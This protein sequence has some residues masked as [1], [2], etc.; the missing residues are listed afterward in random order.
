MAAAQRLASP[1]ATGP[2][3]SSKRSLSGGRVILTSKWQCQP[4]GTRPAWRVGKE[5]ASHS[6]ES[7]PRAL[8]GGL[9]NHPGT[10]T[11]AGLGRS[12]MGVT[13]LGGMGRAPPGGPPP[14]L[15]LHQPWAS[16]EQREPPDSPPPSPTLPR[17]FPQMPGF[18]FHPNEDPLT[19]AQLPALCAVSEAHPQGWPVTEGGPDPL[20]AG[21]EEECLSPRHGAAETTRPLGCCPLYPGGCTQLAQPPAP[22]PSWEGPVVSGGA[23]RRG[24]AG[25]ASEGAG[26]GGA[27]ASA[28]DSCASPGAAR[29][30]INTCRL[31]VQIPGALE[32][33]PP[34]CGTGHGPWDGKER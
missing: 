33:P 8:D 29:A 34:G 21:A 2:S 6:Q 13:R 1:A 19:A 12:L 27:P 5:S 26:S 4:H 20:A 32:Q 25:Q 15:L 31:A 30:R 14:L 10:D 28:S 3:G 24:R 18:L 16:P 17:S 22:A 23:G 11:P 7:T 9:A